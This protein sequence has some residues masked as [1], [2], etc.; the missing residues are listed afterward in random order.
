MAFP[1]PAVPVFH[2][3]LMI[4]PVV[5]ATNAIWTVVAGRLALVRRT[6]LTLSVARIPSSSE[7]LILTELELRLV[8]H[9]L[10]IIATMDI[11]ESL[12]GFRAST[13]WMNLLE[14]PPMLSMP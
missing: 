3:P 13:A 11:C 1:P 12:Q 8:R 10:L 2:S 5:I 9:G 6:T 4:Q 7:L 14:Q